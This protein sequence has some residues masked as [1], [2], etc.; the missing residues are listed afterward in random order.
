MITTRRKFLTTSVG[1]LAS[2]QI[3]PSFAQGA[4]ERINVAFIGCGGKGLHAINSLASNSM[5]NIAAFADVD[6][7]SAAVARAA[8]PNAP[9]HRDLR[10]MLDKHSKDI[11]AVIISTPD[12][13]HHFAAKYAMKAGKHVYVEKPLAHSIA[14][15]R[16]LMALEKETGLACQMGNQG[17]SG[18]GILLLEEWNKAGVLGTVREAY[19]WANATWST[20]DARPPTD[21]VPQELDWDQWLGPAAMVP[22]SAKYLPAQWRSWFDFGGGTLGDWSCHNMDAPYFVWGLDCPSKIEIESSGPSKL[23]FPTSARVTFTFPT[24]RSGGEFKLHWYHGKGNSLPRPPELEADKEMPDGGTIIRGS[25]A[26][27]LMNTHASS[28]RVTPQVKMREIAPSLPKVDTKRSQHYQ[29]WL[30]AIKGI[31]T[32]RSNFAYGGRLTETMLF[33]KIALHVNRDLT[34]DP[35]TRTIVGDPEASALMAGAKPREGWS[36]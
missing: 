16:D 30:L 17:H 6:E 21:P 29:N 8:H 25:K 13:T 9:F 18:S 10:V 19:A 3:L 34:I 15:V 33:A 35:A 23:S 24:S 36:I 31:E 20:A 14:E 22:Y 1:T 2:I 32:C 7:R 12:H 4:N 5:I 11:D 28:P 26:T 27:V